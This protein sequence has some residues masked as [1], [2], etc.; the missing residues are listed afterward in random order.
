MVLK[1][2]VSF[3]REMVVSYR[4]MK[5]FSL[6]RF[7]A[8][9]YVH[10]L[11]IPWHACTKVSIHKHHIQS[12]INAHSKHFAYTLCTLT[13][14]NVTC[15]CTCTQNRDSTHF[16]YTLCTH[17]YQRSMYMHLYVY[18]SCACVTIN[19]IPHRLCG[20]SISCQPMK[21]TS[22]QLHIPRSVLCG[23]SSF[24]TSPSWSPW[25]TCVGYANKIV[26]QS[27]GQQT[28]QK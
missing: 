4:S 11:M 24:L 8:I 5:V 1:P 3:L 10:T 6:E 28:H 25:L 26:W 22:E 20:P 15:T 21:P 2:S 13:H 19:N 18:N 17:T 14:T 27:W 16:T 7:P 12:Y 9:W 23:V